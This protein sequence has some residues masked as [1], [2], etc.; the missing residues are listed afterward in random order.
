MVLQAPQATIGVIML[1][2]GL[3]YTVEDNCFSCQW[4][5]F[6]GVLKNNMKLE[7]VHLPESLSQLGGHLLILCLTYPDVNVSV[8]IPDSQ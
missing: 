3:C 1:M 7:D 2:L 6:Q 5:A 8:W 4:R